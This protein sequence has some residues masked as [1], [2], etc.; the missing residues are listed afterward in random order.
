MADN[1]PLLAIVRPQIDR[2]EA[3]RL[4]AYRDTKGVWTIGWGRADAGVHPGMTCTQAE[5]DQWRDEKLDALCAQI[6]ATEPWWRQMSLPR[7]AVLLEMAYQMG[8]HGL[9]KFPHA[10]ACMQAQDWAGAKAN[11]LDSQ[12]AR[13][14]SPARAQREAE[15]MF[16]GAIAET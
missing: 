8:A 10:L 15:Q 16:T 7:Q 5:A 9:G 6:D 4:R 3:C 14:D 12:W 2:E 1:A 11:L 13:L